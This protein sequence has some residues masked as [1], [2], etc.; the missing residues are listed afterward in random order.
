MITKP[1][2]T[3][4]AMIVA[5]LNCSKIN[6][7]KNSKIN[8]KIIEFFTEIFCEARGRFLV[9]ATF[10]SKFLSNKS[11]IMQPALLIKNPPRV[12]RIRWLINFE[13][14]IFALVLKIKD[15]AKRH[16]KI[17]KALPIGCLKRIKSR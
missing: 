15:N 16:G 10:L 13:D 3:N 11:L 6:S 5:I 8:K 12:K 2:A 9:R 14:S 7:A 17:N 1:R 4:P